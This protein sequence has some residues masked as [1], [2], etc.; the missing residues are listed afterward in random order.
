MQIYLRKTKK[1]KEKKKGQHKQQLNPVK[2]LLFLDALMTN[3]MPMFQEVNNVNS[4]YQ[5]ASPFLFSKYRY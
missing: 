1:K 2:P 3:A 4:L 5:H